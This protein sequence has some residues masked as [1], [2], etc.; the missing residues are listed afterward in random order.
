VPLTVPFV[1]LRLVME[2][3]TLCVID[4][5]LTREEVDSVENCIEALPF[6]ADP[7]LAVMVAETVEYKL[8]RAFSGEK[9]SI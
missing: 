2:S 1:V 7:L 3:A 6:V 5:K 8:S 9:S 4:V